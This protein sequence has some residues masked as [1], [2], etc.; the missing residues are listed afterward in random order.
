LV[1]AHG[2]EASEMN[3][4][5][6]VA[7][8]A[9]RLWS[10][11]RGVFLA[12]RS[13]LFAQRSVLSAQRQMLSAC[14]ACACSMSMLS[15]AAHDAL[16][17]S[18]PD[19]YSACDNGA[20]CKSSDQCCPNAAQCCDSFAPFCCG[21]G[22]CATSPG[23]CTGA[24]GQSCNTYEVPCG[25]G[26]APPGSDCCD[27]TG[28]YCAIQG[29]CTSN[30]TC[31]AGTDVSAA[32]LV[33]PVSVGK[34][35]E[36][37]VSPLRDPPDGSARSCAFAPAR[38]GSGRGRASSAAEMSAALLLFACWARRWARGSSGGSTL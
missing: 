31:I 18:C 35:G 21:D 5:Q 23:L 9:V 22:S 11:W 19:G 1:F 10:V 15:I 28:H 16:A 33:T 7:G 34:D 24:A 2:S 27:S 38:G 17:Q 32:L 12:R 13:V 6:T 37:S 26:C 14:L 20:C 8:F 3:E 30:T 4:R 29:V 36:R 25:P